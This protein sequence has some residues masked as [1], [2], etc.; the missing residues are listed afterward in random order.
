MAAQQQSVAQCRLLA[1]EALMRMSSSTCL[2]TLAIRMLPEGVLVF[3]AVYVWQKNNGAPAV[4]V[5]QC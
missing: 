1:V 5:D 3:S 4:L 2:L